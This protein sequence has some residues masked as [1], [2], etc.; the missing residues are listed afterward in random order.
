[1]ERRHRLGE[2]DDM[3]VVTGAEDVGLHLR[4]PAVRL[5]PEMGAG[6]EE[7]AHREIDG[8]DSL[9]S[10]VDTA[11]ED[12]SRLRCRPPET[13]HSGMGPAPRVEW[14]GR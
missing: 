6:L 10:P 2:V 9:V 1:M 8:H 13:P 4:V 11:A 7:L 12:R 14:A 3:D 5:V